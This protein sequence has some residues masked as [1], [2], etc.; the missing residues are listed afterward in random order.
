[1]TVPVS[2][3]PLPFQASISGTLRNLLATS[4]LLSTSTVSPGNVLRSAEQLGDLVGLA[5]AMLPPIPDAA[6]AML[7]EVPPSPSFGAPLC[8]AV[9]IQ[10]MGRQQADACAAAAAAGLRRAC[11]QQLAVSRH[12]PRVQAATHAW[13]LLTCGL[14]T[15]RAL[16]RADG[17]A[18]RASGG[19]EACQRTQFLRDN[20]ALLQKFSADLLPLMIKVGAAALL[21]GP[22]VLRAS[23]CV[24]NPCLAFL[25]ASSFGQLVGLQCRVVSCRKH[26]MHHRCMA[27]TMQV[28]SSSVTPQ[29]KRQCLTTIAKM[30]HFNTAATLAALLEDL[31]VSALLAAL[32]SARDSTVV[33]FGMQV[34]WLSPLLLARASPLVGKQRTRR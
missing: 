1:M 16:H 18:P 9:H 3:A 21:A 13:A 34:R 19:G 33:A 25:T 29:V 12:S 2:L 24:A 30:L 31:P 26:A 8:A 27:A 15:C 10:R 4:S 14:P 23:G 5:A 28:Y 11:W 22:F 6:A 20:P 32:L 7:R 17:D